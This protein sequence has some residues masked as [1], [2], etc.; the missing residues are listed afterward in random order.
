MSFEARARDRGLDQ[1]RDRRRQRHAGGRHRGV[2]Q[3]HRAVERQPVHGH[4]A[5]DAG[6]DQHQARRD[7]SRAPRHTRGK[8]ASASVT[9]N[10]RHHTS[11]VRRQ[12]DQLAEDRGEAPQHHADVQFDERAAVG[13]HVAVIYPQEQ[14]EYH[15]ELALEGGSRGLLAYD[16][17]LTS[18]EAR[19]ARAAHRQVRELRRRTTSRIMTSRSGKQARQFM[20]RPGE[21]PDHARESCSASARTK[22]AFRTH[23]VIV[24]ASDWAEI[25]AAAA[26]RRGL[27][28]VRPL[29]QLHGDERRRRARR[30]DA[31]HVP[32]VHAFLPGVAVRRR[33]SAVVQRRPGRAHG[34]R[35]VRPRTW[36]CCRSRCIACTKRATATGF[37][38]SG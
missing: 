22:S 5:A 28:P 38:S 2:R 27:V 16:R 13:I 32:R 4:H 1:R 15:A 35:E 18:R 23:I 9:N 11:C 34:L 31:R 8:Q 21:V 33:V 25:P 36:R 10:M 3:L 37:R 6:E 17:G 14:G 20:R 29:R 19:A 26:E 12:R 7:D 30:G 24:S